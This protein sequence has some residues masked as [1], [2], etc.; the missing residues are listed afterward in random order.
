[1][2]AED[3]EEQTDDWKDQIEAVDTEVGQAATT[4][5]E[6]AEPVSQLPDHAVGSGAKAEE[7]QELYLDLC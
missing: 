5:L 1:V 2:Q 4:Q 3:Q 7:M 6:S